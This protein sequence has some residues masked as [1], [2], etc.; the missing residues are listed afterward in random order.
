M[1][2]SLTATE[3]EQFAAEVKEDALKHNCNSQGVMMGAAG[4]IWLGNVDNG[5]GNSQLLIIG[6]NDMPGDK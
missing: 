2:T 6:I 3:V 4:Q 5:E 1:V